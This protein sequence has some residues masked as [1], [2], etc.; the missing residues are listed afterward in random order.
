LGLFETL[1]KISHIDGWYDQPPELII[2]DLH[3]PLRRGYNT[4][5]LSGP[6]EKNFPV[7]FNIFLMQHCC[8]CRRD[9]NR[10]L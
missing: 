6:L 10:R 5:M 3:K 8:E 2:N 1:L 4:S 9:D 7:D